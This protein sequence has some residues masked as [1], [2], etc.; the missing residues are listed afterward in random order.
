MLRK[1]TVAYRSTL[2]AVADVI[3]PPEEGADP[4][5]VRRITL[6]IQS[7]NAIEIAFD[8]DPKSIDGRDAYWPE[9]PLGQW[10]VL[11][12]LASQ[13]LVGRCRFGIHELGVLVEYLR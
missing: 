9:P 5:S 3:V 11:E 7:E 8:C 1:P 6:F 13:T 10:M 12:M 2:S 4:G